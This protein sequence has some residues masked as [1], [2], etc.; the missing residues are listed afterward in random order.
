MIYLICQKTIKVLCEQLYEKTKSLS[1]N[2]CGENRFET[3][4]DLNYTK[5]C[6]CKNDGLVSIYPL[7]DTR[8]LDKGV[9]FLS[10]F[11]VDKY[12]SLWES[13]KAQY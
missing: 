3:I 6:K 7:I 2:I 1:C 11:I 9:K 13:K 8:Q 4:L 12:N 5:L 10:E